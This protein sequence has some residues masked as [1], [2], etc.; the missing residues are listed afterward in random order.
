MNLPCKNISE[1]EI[2]LAA[3]ELTEG[4]WEILFGIRIKKF[5]ETSARE[6]IWYTKIGAETRECTV[7][8]AGK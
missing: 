2:E 4:K 6:D 5:L 8:K 7:G 1:T 3:R